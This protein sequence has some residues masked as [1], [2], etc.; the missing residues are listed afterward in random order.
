MLVSALWSLG[1]TVD[2]RS[3]EKCP[4]FETV[5]A[6]P[7]EVWDLS[8]VVRVGTPEDEEPELLAPLE[9]VELALLAEADADFLRVRIT[10]ENGEFDF[11]ALD[12]GRYLLSACLPGFDALEVLVEVTSSAPVGPVRILL[13]VAEGGGR[14]EAFVLEG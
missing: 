8:G 14:S 5:R 3:Y 2:E 1:A 7:F 9:G 12:A 4:T 11:G 13:G 10:D 6:P